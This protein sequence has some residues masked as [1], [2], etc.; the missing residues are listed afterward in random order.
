MSYKR[1]NDKDVRKEQILAASLALA[2]SIGYT[3]V[4]ADRAA[5]AVQCVPG[6]VRHHFGTKAQFHR[7]LIRYAISKQNLTVIAQGLAAKDKHAQKA[8]E[9]LKKKALASLAA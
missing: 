6:T 4:S 1:I 9:C 5:A 7:A 3:H 8:P 2:E